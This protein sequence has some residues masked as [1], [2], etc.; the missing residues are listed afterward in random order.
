MHEAV[1]ATLFTESVADAQ[2][3]RLLPQG[4]SRDFAAQ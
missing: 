3:P 1:T 4:H 2:H